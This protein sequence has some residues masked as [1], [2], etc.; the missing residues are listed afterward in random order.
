[1]ELQPH[2]AT[3]TAPTEQLTGAVHVDSLS[4]GP[5]HAGPI[6]AAVHFAPGARMHGHRHATGQTCTAPTG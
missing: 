6:A 5:D 1:M 4:A 3:A 2:P